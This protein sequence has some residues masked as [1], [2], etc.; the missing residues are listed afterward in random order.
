MSLNW[1]SV[2]GNFDDYLYNF[3]VP[4]EAA[5]T[6]QRWQPT[7]V[8]GDITIGI[9]F[10]L[11]A[12]GKPAQDAVLDELGFDPRTVALDP[13]NPPPSGPALIEFTYISAIRSAIAAGNLPQL[14]VLMQARA[15]VA[16]TNVAYAQFLAQPPRT[17]FAFQNDTEVRE[18]FDTLWPN[19]YSPY[20]SR[21]Y[22]SLASDAGF[23]NSL[24]LVA[25]ASLVW[26]GGPGIL[27]TEKAGLGQAIASGNRAEA[28]F[29]IRYQRNPHQDPAVARRRYYES[30]V[31]GLFDNPGAPTY[32]EAV[33]AYQMLTQ[34]RSTIIPYETIFGADPDGSS[35][36]ASVP[37]AAPS[38]APNAVVS[39]PIDRRP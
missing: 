20:I 5:T 10:D 1:Q 9:G 12:G 21:H 17:S 31:F 6:Q 11:K 23:Q 16:S 22:P 33:Q 26:N 39:F 3:L 27:G 38:V 7:L 37:S 35:G 2:P 18:V 25:L 29:Q 24:E 36:S 30:Q 28:W 19:V 8:N 14:N 34:H 13:A 32:A 15:Q 4:L